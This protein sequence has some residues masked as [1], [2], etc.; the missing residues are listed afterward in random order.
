[1][2]ELFFGRKQEIKILNKALQSDHAELI[3]VIGRRRVGKTFLIRSAYKGKIDFEMTGI[4]K[5]TLQEQLQH[6]TNRLNFHIKPVLPYAVPSNWLEAFQMLTIYFDH[7]DSK[8]KIVFFFDELP[9]IATKRSGFLKAFGVF[10]NTWASQ[11]NV[12][13]VICGSAASWMIQK[14]VRDKGG[15][16]NRITRR[17][18][19]S[20]F[21][22]AETK[23][24]LKAKKYNFDHYQIIQL[25]MAMGGIPH[26]LKEIEGGQ[27][28]AQNI[29]RIFFSKS[30]FLKEEF[31]LLY[32]AL[33]ENAETHIKIIKILAEKWKGLTRKELIKAGKFPNGGTLTKTIEEL[34]HAG[35][36]APF[37][38]FGKKKNGLHYRLIDEYSIFYLKFLHN[39]RLEERGMWKKFSQTQTY[40]I[41]TGFAFE[42]ICLKHLAQIKK[43]LNISGVYTETSIYRKTGNKEHSGVQIDLLIDRNDHI[44]N[45]LELKFY[46]TDFIVSKSY[47][48]ELSQKMEIFRQQTKTKKQLFWTLLTTF[49]LEKNEHSLGLLDQTLTMDVLFE[50]ETED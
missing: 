50:E 9:W 14:V 10:W 39:K 17:I 27:S 2:K 11:N 22:L 26:Y 13:I 49:G 38:T 34:V 7:L 29:D 35:F 44:I 16:H 46:N 1:M 20:P 3:A 23:A 30:G 5:G 19:L 32:P 41:W 25:Y 47:A 12:V 45:L 15:L 21:D 24:Y 43:A 37:Y 40:K 6:F 8:E 36:I 48:K 33:F 28:A 42:N 31:D 18:E 4:Q